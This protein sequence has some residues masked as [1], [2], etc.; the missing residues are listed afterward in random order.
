[1]S[2]DI[3]FRSDIKVK[4]VKHNVKDSDVAMAARVS[5][6]GGSH[7]EPVDL[8]KD[9]GLINYLMRDRHG[10]PFEHGSLTFYIEAPIFVAR[11]HFRHRAGWSYNEESGRYKTLKPSFYVPGPDR[12]L[13]QVGKP[14]AYTFEPGTG[15]QKGLVPYVM[16]GTYEAIYGEYE[17]MLLHGIAKEVARMILPVGLMTSYYATCNP[18]SLMH[19]LSLRTINDESTY[20]SFPQKEIEMVADEMEEVFADAMPITWSAFMRHGRVSP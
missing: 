18:R 16:R 2:T 3:E 17:A 20:P 10:S 12:N 13:V 8:T 9:E 5:T 15:F 14:G 1:M 6:I 11:E 7:E 4:L 19:F